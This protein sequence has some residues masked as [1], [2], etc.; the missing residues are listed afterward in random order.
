[1][2]NFVENDLMVEVLEKQRLVALSGSDNTKWELKVVKLHGKKIALE[3]E[4]AKQE[5][6]TN[7][8]KL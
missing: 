4:V 5:L 6:T 1:M 8:Q 2:P 7:G 3:H